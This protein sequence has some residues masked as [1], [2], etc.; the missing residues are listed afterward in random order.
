M[1][2]ILWAFS[3]CLP[4]DLLVV[5]GDFLDNSF[6]DNNLFRVVLDQYVPILLIIVIAI[7]LAAALLSISYL[8]GPKRYG[9]WRKFIPYESGMVPRGDAREK[10]SLKYYLIGALFIL[11]DI[12]IVFLA[13]WAVVFRE[14][15]MLALIEVLAF[16]VV[17]MSGYFYV[18]KKGALEWE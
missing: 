3:H 18:L 5:R 16:L 1:L 10:I 12:E 9:S 8:L 13:V 17:V 6:P 2:T 11:F 7:V 14:L 15:G 4:Q